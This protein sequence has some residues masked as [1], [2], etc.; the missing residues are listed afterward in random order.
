MSSPFPWRPEARQR[1]HDRCRDRRA[2]DQHRAEMS[3]LRLPDGSALSDRDKHARDDEHS[4]QHGRAEHQCQLHPHRRRTG[5]QSNASAKL[6][7][8][9]SWSGAVGVKRSRAGRRLRQPVTLPV[10]ALRA[11]CG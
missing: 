5:N 9:P 3:V 10:F 1:V 2:A 4:D 8:V 11:E 7:R 6:C